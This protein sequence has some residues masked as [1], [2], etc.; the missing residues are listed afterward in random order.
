VGERCGGAVDASP[1]LRFRLPA[2]EVFGAATP[3]LSTA[4]GLF[5]IWS[6]LGATSKASLKSASGRTVRSFARLLT[7][8]SFI[9]AAISASLASCLTLSPER[10]RTA[11]PD[12]ERFFAD[13]AAAPEGD[14]KSRPIFFLGDLEGRILCEAADKPGCIDKEDDAV[15]FADFTRTSAD[16]VLDF[17]DDDEGMVV[18]VA[19]LTFSFSSGAKAPRRG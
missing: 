7:C 1:E 14:A 15:D 6:S 9:R 10:V 16:L 18:P 13:A 8:A 12:T 4:I 5:S 11:G 19:G 2:T 17:E 3:A